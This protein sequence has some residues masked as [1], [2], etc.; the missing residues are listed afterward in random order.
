MVD[1]IINHNIPNNPKNYVHRVGRTARAGRGGMAITFVTQFD[2]KLVQAVE[3]YINTKL[4]LHEV[5]EK[6]VTKILVEVTLAKSE[7]EIVLD[8]RDFGEYKKIHKQKRAILE[9]RDPDEKEMERRKRKR[10]DRTQQRA[11]EALS[12]KANECTEDVASTSE[13]RPTKPSPQHKS[14]KMKKKK[15]SLKTSL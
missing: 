12:K 2:I 11:R 8:E 14:L 5:D 15:G 1:L 7:A 10:L 6:E 9:G 4:K 13:S 3:A